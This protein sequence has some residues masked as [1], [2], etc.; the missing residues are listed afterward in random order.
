MRNAST[1][2]NNPGPWSLMLSLTWFHLFASFS[3]LCVCTWSIQSHNP[4]PWSL[5]CSRRSWQQQSQMLKLRSHL[6]VHCFQFQQCLEQYQH[7]WP[8]WFSLSMVLL[9]TTSSCSSTSFHVVLV[10]NSSTTVVTAT[11]TKSLETKSRWRNIVK[12][13]MK[14]SQVKSWSCTL[15]GWWLSRK[16]ICWRTLRI[17]L[18]IHCRR[19]PF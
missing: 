5:L 1:S 19:V 9:T 11:L 17:N 6:Q 12:S 8:S 3:L 14:N 16:M 2:W 18:C 15:V 4:G 13:I 10:S 7:A